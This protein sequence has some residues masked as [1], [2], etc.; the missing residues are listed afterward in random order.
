MGYA[1]YSRMIFL[2]NPNNPTGHMLTRDQLKEI[3]GFCK[4]HSILMVL[5]ECFIPLTTRAKECTMVGE[6][7]NYPNL[8]LLKAFTKLYAMPGL[9]LGYGMTSNLQLLEE[10]ASIM[11]PWSVSIPAQMAG[12]AALKE[13]DYAAKTP[14]YVAERRVHLRKEMQDL[15]LTVYPGEANYLFFKGPQG[16]YDKCQERG[17]LIR[18]CSNYIGLREGLLSCSSS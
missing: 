3:A 2:C 7:E 1:G 9:R 6:L 5:D 16:L 17:I 13:K 10:L 11:Q 4:D 15:G 18:D 8:F 14:V 12:V